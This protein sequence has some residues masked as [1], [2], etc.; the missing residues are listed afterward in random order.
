[1]KKAKFINLFL[2]IGLLSIPIT[3]SANSLHLTNNINNPIVRQKIKKLPDRTGTYTIKQ[4]NTIYHIHVQGTN[5]MPKTHQK[6]Y[7]KQ[8]IQ[9]ATKQYRDQSLNDI[10]QDRKHYYDGSIK[11]NAKLDHLAQIRSQQ[12][13]QHFSHYSFSDQPMTTVDAQRVGLPRDFQGSE[14]IASG[15][16]GRCTVAYDPKTYNNPNGNAMAD[17]SNDG[18][19]NYD[20]F[21]HNGHRKNILSQSNTLIGVG[22]T[23]NPQKHTFYVAEDFGSHD[24][25]SSEDISK[26]TQNQQI[27]HQIN[28]THHQK[29]QFLT[30]II[31]KVNHFFKS[32]INKI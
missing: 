31:K 13:S 1:M 6:T 18:M 25:D 12:I 26:A 8:Q 14:N 9:Q 29:E 19:M 17:M 27:N 22:A 7:T 4:G 15:G 21:E 28:K 5:F 3:A 16:L 24:P 20:Q 2:V 32:L 23:Y 10:R 30:K 11:E